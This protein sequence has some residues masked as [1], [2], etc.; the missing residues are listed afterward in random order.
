MNLSTESILL[1]VLLLIIVIPQAV[2]IAQ[3]RGAKPS[4]QSIWYDVQDVAAVAVKAAEQMYGTDNAAKFA[5]V[6]KT[7]NQWLLNVGMS[8]PEP[9]VTALLE[10]AVRQFKIDTK[11]ETS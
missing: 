8:L 4:L 3:K 10:S 1:I 11:S 9:V 6:A 7:I 2:A 5:F